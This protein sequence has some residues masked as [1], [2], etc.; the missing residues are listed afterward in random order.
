MGDWWV[1]TPKGTTGG[2]GLTAC[3]HV[4]T[5][6]LV[7]AIGKL[8]HLCPTMAR[9][10]FLRQLGS[11]HGPD[12]QLDPLWIPSQPCL[13]VVTTRTSLTN[14]Q[15]L[16]YMPFILLYPANYVP[17]APGS[18]HD[19]LSHSP[20]SVLLG[21][22]P[23]LSI[24]VTSTPGCR[25]PC[26]GPD[27]SPCSLLQTQHSTVSGKD[28]ILKKKYLVTEW[29]D[30]SIFCIPHCR[31]CLRTDLSGRFLQGLGEAPGLWGAR[32]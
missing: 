14:T 28:W 8:S 22:Y 23:A 15:C 6:A 16:I 1:S 30:E 12:V 5:A 19:H 7:E 3:P 4:T 31:K 2:W 17:F 18:P 9:E 29:M 27:T 11:W 21:C 32:W 24:A 26:C 10:A 13:F 20:F 25:R